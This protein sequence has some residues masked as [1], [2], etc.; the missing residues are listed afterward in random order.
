MDIHIR[1]ATLA[2]TNS[3][4]SAQSSGSGASSPMTAA[5]NRY[6][7]AAGVPS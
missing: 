5:M 1:L 7:Y 2:G 6:V 3:T 4:N